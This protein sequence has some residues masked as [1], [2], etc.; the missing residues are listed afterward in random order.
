M[1][2]GARGAKGRSGRGPPV[3]PRPSVAPIVIASR[4]IFPDLRSVNTISG[5]VHVGGP[6]QSGTVVHG[7]PSTLSGHPPFA[8]RI[9]LISAVAV[10]GSNVPAANDCRRIR[11]SDGREW[12]RSRIVRA[13]EAALRLQEAATS[14]AT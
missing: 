5:T 10:F 4:G 1:T 14:A 2:A 6:E 9:S 3:W 7:I 13:F 12:S 8:R 11:T